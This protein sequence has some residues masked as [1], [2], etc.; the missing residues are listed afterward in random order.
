MVH[1]VKCNDFRKR[2]TTL[3]KRW[4]IL[5]WLGV[6]TCSVAVESQKLRPYEVSVK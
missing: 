2:Q 4:R 6:V 1:K 3:V 5:I